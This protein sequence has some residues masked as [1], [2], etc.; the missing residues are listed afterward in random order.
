LDSKNFIIK[1]KTVPE[2]F[3][4]DN[5]I[6]GVF[7]WN[8]ILPKYFVAVPNNT[9]ELC[10]LVSRFSEV[11]GGP[12][13]SAFVS[14]LNDGENRKEGRVICRLGVAQAGPTPLLLPAPPPC[15]HGRGRGRPSRPLLATSPG[16][17]RRG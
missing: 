2:A 10:G 9:K 12:Q 16:Q 7:K 13:N 8:Q 5:S 3:K 15:Q 1:F 4:F 6:C 17:V 11:F 14:V